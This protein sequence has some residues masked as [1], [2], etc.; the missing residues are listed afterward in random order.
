[1]GSARTALGATRPGKDV[2]V[3]GVRLAYDD[4]GAGPALVCLHAIGHGARDFVPLTERIGAGR[5]VIALDWPGHGSS[6]D[7]REPPF[8]ARYEAL[9]A[10]FL[11]ALGVERATLL[12]N[13][14]GGAAALRFAAHSPARVQALVLVD[15][16]GLDKGGVLARVV[17]AAMAR[18]FDAGARGARWYPAAFAA[19]YRLVLPRASE[20]RARIVAAA[21]ESAAVLAQAWRGF[22]EPDADVRALAERVCCPTLV[23]WAKGDRI[24]QLSRCRPALQRFANARLEIFSGGHAP[25]LEDL[26]AFAPV[27]EAF[28][29]ET[30]RVDTA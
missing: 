22:A 28:L 27:L 5:R 1:M 23:A 14:I 21:R 13:S 11:D 18:F 19:Y 30:E 26:D 20:R 24:N 16:G 25:F 10:G 6:A 15:P 7:D 29:R 8:A 12:G 3:D 9:L 2:V 17:P 4:A